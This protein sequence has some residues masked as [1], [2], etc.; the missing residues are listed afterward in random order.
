MAAKVA[1]DTEDAENT[2]MN[3]ADTLDISLDAGNA[4]NITMVSEDTKEILPVA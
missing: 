3:V 4:K 2:D 1:M